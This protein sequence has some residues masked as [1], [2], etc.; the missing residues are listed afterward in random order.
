MVEDIATPAEEEEVV[1]DSVAV[2][3]RGKLKESQR[4]RA[5]QLE[6]QEWKMRVEE[7]VSN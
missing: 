3:K 2:W 7:R 5:S 1:A 4:E 6:Q